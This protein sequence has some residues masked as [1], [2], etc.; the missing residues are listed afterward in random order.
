MKT[1]YENKICAKGSTE[2]KVNY[3][4]DYA[5][6]FKQQIVSCHVKCLNSERNLLAIC[7]LKLWNIKQKR[8][9]GNT[10]NKQNKIKK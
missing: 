4:V 8:K 6:N 5:A 2:G 3:N 9:P 1:I 7:C 10:R